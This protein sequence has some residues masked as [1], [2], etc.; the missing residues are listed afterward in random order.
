LIGGRPDLCLLIFLLLM[1]HELLETFQH[2]ILKG[3]SELVCLAVFHVAILHNVFF[4]FSH[5]WSF[6][7]SIFEPVTL[8][9]VR[10]ENLAQTVRSTL[11]SLKYISLPFGKIR[12]IF[13]VCNHGFLSL[14]L[15]N[16]FWLLLLLLYTLYFNFPKIEKFI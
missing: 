12:L 2:L 16:H 7:G 1:F 6:F 14:I 10:I 13:G 5:Y 8:V 11:F 15:L 3:F 4:S 9:L